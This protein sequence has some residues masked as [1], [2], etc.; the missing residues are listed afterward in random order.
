VATGDAFDSAWLWSAATGELLAPPFKHAGPV[1]EVAFSPD[2]RQLLTASHDTT[3]RIWDIPA[4]FN[5]P[6]HETRPW[7][8]SLTGKA[9]D[10]RG[11]LS[12]LDAETWGQRRKQIRLAP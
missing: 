7:I 6:I 5:G 8:E 3:A 4:S 2:G 9:M 12:W 1:N 10:E 11:V